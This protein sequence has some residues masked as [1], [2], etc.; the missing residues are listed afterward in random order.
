MKNLEQVADEL[1]R[2]LT[3]I[4]LLDEEGRAGSVR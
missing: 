1:A 4:F 2:R 3:R